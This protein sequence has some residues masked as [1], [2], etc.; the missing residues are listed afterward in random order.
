MNASDTEYVTVSSPYTFHVSKECF[1]QSELTQPSFHPASWK[2]PPAGEGSIDSELHD[3]QDSDCESLV[4]ERQYQLELQQRIRANDE[5]VGLSAGQLENDSLEEEDSLEKTSSE[6]QEGAREQQP[7]D[8]YFS[9]KYN[10]NW[11]NTK[12]AVEFSEVEKTHH[13]AEGG[14]VDL[15]QDSFYLHSSVSSGEKNQQEAKFQESFSEFGTE[16]LSFHE[17]NA[18]ICSEPFRLHTR[19]NE[20]SDGYYFKDSLSTYSSAFSLRIPEDR[21]QRAKKDFVEKNKRTLGLR[22][23]KNKSYL[24]LHG[25]KQEV[26]QEQVADTKTV[27]E[28]PAQS[29]LPYPNM[30]MHPE[31]KWYLNS[32][33]LKDHQNKWSQRNK[34]KSNQNLEGRAC[35]KSDNHQQAGRPAKPKSW[36][37]RQYQMSEFQTAPLQA[38]EQVNSNALQKCPNPSVGPDTNTAAN[39][40]TC[41]NNFPACTSKNNKN[42][43]HDRPKG[44]PHGQ[45][46]LYNHATVPFFPR[47]GSTSAQAHPNLKKSSSTFNANYQEMAKDQVLLQDC[48]R[49]I[50]ATSSLWPSQASVHSSPAAFCTAFQQQTMEQQYQEMSCL[51]E[52]DDLHLFSPL[53]PLIPHRE[54]D[55]EVDSERGEG[56]QVKISRSNSEGY[57]MQMEKQKQRKVCKKPYSSKACI[58]LDVK[59]GG[60]GPDYEAIK[61]KKEK[62]KQQKEYAQRIKEHNMKNIALVQRLPTKP[63]VISSVSRQKALE[64]AKKIPKPKT[65]TARQSDEEVKEERVLLPTLKGDSLPPITSLETLQSRHEK[66]KQV[67]AAFRTLHIL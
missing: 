24:Q 55:S 56:N 63:Q 66:E 65:F 32:Q 33:Q 4:L 51:R 15:S 46:H 8:K 18:F 19:G 9:L 44:L 17:P 7:V 11:K 25:K 22:T 61:E 47:D 39:S 57:L 48:K 28:E 26:I 54:S 29:A 59:L 37:Y 62:L 45:Q 23:D 64:Y 49:Q 34:V 38:V 30:K 20:S 36:H 53:P 27:D 13:V 12:E 10:P 1:P 43:Q 41:L 14:S 16:L 50:Y 21:P 35:S 3:C 60:L 2:R 31:D 40:D 67:V 42:Y 58:N 5:L 52:A 6:E